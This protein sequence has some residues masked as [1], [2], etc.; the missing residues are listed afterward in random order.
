MKIIN[1]LRESKEELGKVT[2]P[3]KNDV[4]RY[5]AIVIAVSLAV[6]AFFFLLDLG[7]SQGFAT[8]LKISS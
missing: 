2:W 8:L 4:T 3:T 7:F 6:G 1:Y 5:S